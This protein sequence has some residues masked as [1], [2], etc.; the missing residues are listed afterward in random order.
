M[1][2]KLQCYLAGLI[3]WIR[4]GIPFK[5]AM[6]AAKEVEKITREN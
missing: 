6:N 2:H 1:L 4:F 3:I 5:E